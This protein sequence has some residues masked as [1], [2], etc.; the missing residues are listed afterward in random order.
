MAT[1]IE[2]III[3]IASPEKRVLSNLHC[4]QVDSGR[5]GEMI[6]WLGGMTLDA[7]TGEE[8]F[9]PRFPPP[10]FHGLP[11]FLQIDVFMKKSIKLQ[12]NFVSLFTYPSA[13]FA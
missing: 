5:S 13:F 2:I 11:W 1:L 12:F 10:G 8:M 9:V 7:A 4:S 3:I 6:A